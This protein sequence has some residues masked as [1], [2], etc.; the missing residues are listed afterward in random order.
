[1]KI[2]MF[3]KSLRDKGHDTMALMV[4]STFTYISSAGFGEEKCSGSISDE[5]SSLI[6]HVAS[7]KNASG[8]IV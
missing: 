6:H 2:K 1:M 3:K 4:K 7:H 5:S 8:Q